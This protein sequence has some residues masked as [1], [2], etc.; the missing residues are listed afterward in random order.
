MSLS[1][2]N[3]VP[4]WPAQSMGLMVG[5]SAMQLLSSLVIPM[6]YWRRIGWR[7][8]GLRGGAPIGV[9]RGGSMGAMVKDTA[10]QGLLVMAVAAHSWQY[11]GVGC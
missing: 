1:L 9:Q 5:C 3:K 2:G 4:A 8:E 6:R 10:V 7:C 11:G